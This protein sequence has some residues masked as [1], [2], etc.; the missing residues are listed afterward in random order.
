MLSSAPIIL[1]TYCRPIAALL[2][3]ILL[4]AMSPRWR[5]AILVDLALIGLYGYSA[6]PRALILAA[7]LAAVRWVPAFAAVIAGALNV[8]TWGGL[9][10]PVALFALP[11]L[12]AYTRGP[13][14]TDQP[15]ASALPMPPIV[16]STGRT[17]RLEASTVAARVMAPA[18]WMRAVND[19]PTAPHLGVVGPTRLGKTTFVLAALGRRPGELVI[20]TPKGAD[21]DPWGNAE[22][23]RLSIDLQTRSFDWRPI[24]GAIDRVYYEMLHRYATHGASAAEPITLVVDELSTTFA[25]TPKDTKRQVLELWNMGAGA[26]I[27]LIVIDPE[28]SAAAWG[29]Q[30]RR[31]IL[32]NLVFARVAPGRLWAV[33]RLDPNGGLLSPIPLDTDSLLALAGESRLGGRG[34]AGAAPGSAGAPGGVPVPPRLPPPL[35]PREPCREPGTGTERRSS[36]YAS[37]GTQESRGNRRG[38]QALHSV[39]IIGPKPGTSYRQATYRQ[40]TG[41]LS[42]NRAEKRLWHSAWHYPNRALEYARS[43]CGAMCKCQRLVSSAM[44]L[45]CSWRCLRPT[46]RLSLPCIIQS[47]LSY[48]RGWSVLPSSGCTS[49]RWPCRARSKTRLGSSGLTTWPWE[50]RSSMSPCTLPASTGR[51]MGWKRPS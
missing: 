41:Y 49:E 23:T 47:S 9:S 2:I 29:V 39:T 46:P 21:T 48:S 33:G 37:C 8:P 6:S 43:W 27:R 32:G 18:E 19:D 34:W 36:C 12:A 30:G 15:Q 44:G 25:N 10:L 14:R 13:T 11:G 51:L 24:A 45:R 5:W 50:P 28:V 40:P 16:A 35:W 20:T 7:A 4:G 31:D 3:V 26:N 38:T 22:T 17:T 42:S 1:T